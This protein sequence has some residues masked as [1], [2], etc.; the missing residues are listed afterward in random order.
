MRRI[1]ACTLTIVLLLSAGAFAYNRTEYKKTSKR[2][3]MSAIGRDKNPN[4][5]EDAY[6]SAELDIDYPGE[7]GKNHNRMEL[8]GYASVWALGSGGTYS[9]SAAAYMK[10]KNEGK[11]WRWFLYRGIDAQV[12]LK[13]DPNDFDC[14]DAFAKDYF[15]MVGANAQITNST[16][17]NFEGHARD[18]SHGEPTK[19]VCK[20]EDGEDNHGEDETCNICE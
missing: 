13:Y 17:Q 9:I 5:S 8:F 16:G 6:A 15:Y 11:K 12:R 20:D 19:W 7:D 14:S 10:Y 3:W 1:L 2:Y 18:F 4:G